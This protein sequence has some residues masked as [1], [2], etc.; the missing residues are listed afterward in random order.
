MPR[1]GATW[2]ESGVPACT[3]GDLREVWSCNPQPG[4]GYR[5]GSP[6]RRFA[7]A[8]ASVKASQA[9][10]PSKEGIFKGDS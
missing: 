6:P 9:F 1:C 10:T 2:D 5:P 4:V 3:R 7:T 8:V